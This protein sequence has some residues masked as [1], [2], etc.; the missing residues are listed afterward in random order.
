[1]FGRWALTGRMPRYLVQLPAAPVGEGHRGDGVSAGHQR[2]G[3][4]VFHNLN[5]GTHKNSSSDRL[6]TVVR[7]RLTYSPSHPPGPR[8]AACGPAGRSASLRGVS[9]CFWRARIAPWCEW[10][11]NWWCNY[12]AHAEVLL[13][14][15]FV[16]L[17]RCY[18]YRLSHGWTETA[19]HR[20]CLRPVVFF[21]PWSHMSWVFFPRSN[22]ARFCLFKSAFV[23]IKYY[24]ETLQGCVSG[25]GLGSV[26]RDSKW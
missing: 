8:T 3:R 5:C 2:S 24:A 15:S 7:W 4:V 16:F 1:M 10:R 19:C 22:D 21:P 25:T 11:C 14:F 13:H 20:G 9:S 26:D 18:P 6:E 17:T 23:S 12:S